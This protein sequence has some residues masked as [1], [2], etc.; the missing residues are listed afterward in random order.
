MLFRIKGKNQISKQNFN[1]KVNSWWI[2]NLWEPL[3]IWVR[4]SL[5]NFIWNMQ[6]GIKFTAARFLGGRKKKKNSLDM[7]TSAPKERQPICGLILQVIWSS[8]R[9]CF[10]YCLG[11]IT[12]NC[13][14]DQGS[15]FTGFF[16][17]VP[18]GSGRP[19]GGLSLTLRDIFFA[20]FSV[21]S[22]LLWCN[23]QKQFLK[24]NIYLILV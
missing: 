23:W 15:F 24:T 19:F 21:A 2:K 13:C 1:I 22:S 17:S 16:Q 9:N 12:A 5:L 14:W 7:V 20:F 3:V 4:H 8:G 11:G 10:S 6:L 18:L